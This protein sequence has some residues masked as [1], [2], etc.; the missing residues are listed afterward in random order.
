MHRPLALFVLLGGALAAGVR[1][2]PTSPPVRTALPGEIVTHVFRV[3]GEGGPYTPVFTSSAGFP[4]LSRPRPVTPP[5]YLPVTERV[6]LNAREGTVD[7]LTVRLGDAVAEVRTRVGFQPGVALSVPA[8]VVFVPPLALVQA[9]VEN[10]GNGPDAFLLRLTRKGEVLEFHRLDLGAGKGATLTLGLPRPGVYQVEVVE[11]RAGRKV[12]RSLRAERP[13]HGPLAPFRLVG[14]AA[15]GYAWPGNGVAASFSLAGAVSDYLSLKAYGVWTWPGTGLFSFDVTGDGWAAGADLGPN[16]AGRLA[17]WEGTTSVR[18]SGGT[19]TW[20][21]ADLGFAAPGS[22]HLWSVS[23]N[24]ALRLDLTGAG[25]PSRRISYSYGFSLTGAGASGSVNVG[26]LQESR[27]I[28]LGYT[29]E[30]ATGKP[31]AQRFSL[32]LSDT[33]GSAGATAAL[34]GA[35]LTDWSLAAASTGRQLFGPRAPR[36]SLGLEINAEHIA[37]SG[38]ARLWAAPEASVNLDAAYRWQG[39]ASA[40]A[41]FRLDLPPPFGGLSAGARLDAGRFSTYLEADAEPPIEDARLALSGRLAY[42]WEDSELVARAHLGGSAS[43]LE[44]AL[45]G[46]PFAPELLL[47]VTG[48]TPIGTGLLTAS[49][50]ARYPGGSY[51]F[52]LGARLPILL[53]VPEPVAGFFGGRRVGTVEGSLRPDVPVKSLAGV[54][55]VAGAFTAE[56]DAAGQFVLRLPPGRY[57]LRL[58]RGTL[59]VELVPLKTEVTLE[60]KAKR[61]VAVAFPLEVR[62]RLTGRV[63]VRIEKGRKPPR[64][65][66]AVEVENAAGRRIALYTDTDGAFDLPGLRPGTYTVHL[67]KDFL[68][69]GYRALIDAV[70]VRLEPGK[71][72]QVVLVVQA[73]PRKV[74]RPGKV[75]ILS[76]KPEVQAAPPG[77]APLVA[78]ELKGRPDRLVVRYRNRILGVLLPTE[79]TGVWRGRV[80]VPKDARGPLPLELVA[81]AG[82]AELARF[83]FFLAVDPSA[84]WGQVRT[85]PLAK[86]GQKG[87]PVFV[88]LYA[89]ATAVALAVSGRTYSLTGEGA[90]W[91]GA[92][93]VPVGAKGRFKLV[94]RARLASGRT[95]ELVRFVLVR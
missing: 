4:I 21:R 29:G 33:W 44:L 79:K 86:P 43:F 71:S 77:A 94:V 93:D 20:A 19:G 7:V 57:T 24:P 10:R 38:Q 70:R 73:P 81:G 63:E 15:F 37:F 59:P 32:G 83:P 8:K 89:P 16:V 27:Q 6:P 69:P 34:K 64:V 66:F 60:V 28:T 78:A 92:Y 25:N 26:I 48:Q 50:Q 56:T 67:L 84:P 42:P 49:A 23:A 75:Q 53:T 51:A 45:R 76:V 90:D 82:E 47:G 40:D 54:R 35:T 46:R 65:R 1:I 31:Y 41:R 80:A 39:T 52:S 72:A 95:V 22:R 30:Y 12:V 17:F 5:A 11:V 91:R 18:F 68:P 62:A 3:E 88:H 85:L 58:D 9:R 2:A 74:F 13:E 55:V 36:S 61:K 14:Q 87:V